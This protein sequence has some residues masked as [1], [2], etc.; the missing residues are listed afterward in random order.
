[1]HEST[2]IENQ[3]KMVS[4]KKYKEIYRMNCLIG[5]RNSK[6]I[7]LMNVLQQSLGET[8]SL[9]IETLPSHLMNYQSRAKVEPGSGKHR[10]NTHFPKD[11]NCDICLKTP[12]TRSSCRRRAGTVVPRAEHFGD[13]NTADHNVLSKESESRNNHRYA[14]VVQD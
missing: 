14:V 12:I 3:K 11:P 4:Q 8:L 9:D 5:Y 13:L 6:R 2:E 1:M 10:K 7:W